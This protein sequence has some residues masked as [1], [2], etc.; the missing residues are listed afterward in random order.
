MTINFSRYKKVIIKIGSALLVAGGSGMADDGDNRGDVVKRK[1]L[2]TLVDDIAAMRKNGHEVV[3]VSS[4]AT[5]LGRALLNIDKTAGEELETKQAASAIGQIALMAAWR[6]AF[7]KHDI[8]VAQ[9]LLT[10]QDTEE[11]HRHLNGRA[12]INGLLSR[13]VIPIVNENDSVAT[14]ELKY[15]DNDRLSARVAS[16][17]SA[18]L[19]VLL[20]DVDGLYDKN[21]KIDKNAKHIDSVAE[22]T[23]SI[24]D[25]ASNTNDSRA[26]GGMITKLQAGKIANG[27]GVDMII[28][29]GIFEH[30]LQQLLSGQAKATIF[31]SRVS[32]MAA[33]KKW[34]AGLLNHEG[35]MVID[36]GALTAVRAGKSLL[37][38]GVRQ[39]VAENYFEKGAAILIKN[40]KGQRV[41]VGPINHDRDD[42]IKM[43]G[44]QSGEIKKIF[45]TA[46]KVELID[47]DN[48]ILD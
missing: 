44:K 24:M 27:A 14:D 17:V 31:T 5:A 1:W 9:I 20:S 3:L 28:A 8:L 2:A 32:T 22:V 15:G 38:A 19:L 37:P 43:I 34:I 45:A 39:L 29:S 48:F 26:T 4:G 33:R 12:T 41:G 7:A 25:L 16:M 42:A 13:G 10:P 6:D 36:D 47:R 46:M 21:P 35:E 30:P 40:A 18:D 23:D 11:R